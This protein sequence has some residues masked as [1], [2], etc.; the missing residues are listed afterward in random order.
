[1]EGQQGEKEIMNLLV[2][3]LIAGITIGSIYS[4]IAIGF[5]LIFKSSGVINFA[6][7]SLVM[8]GAFITYAFVTQFKVPIFLS[9]LITFLISGAIGMIIERFV[10]RYL[11]GVSLISIIMV[12][13]G[14]SFIMDG[15]RWRQGSSNLPSQ[16]FFHLYPFFWV[17]SRFLRFT[18]GVL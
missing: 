18:S 17:E 16:A 11:T 15:G 6:Q 5:F 1:M 14:I 10:L 3:V 12:T 8:V 4:L 9:I 2:Q 7:G 13:M